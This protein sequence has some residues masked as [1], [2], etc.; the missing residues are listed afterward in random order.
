MSFYFPFPEHTER[1]F[2]S[3][4]CS[5]V[6]TQDCSR[7]WTSA[8]VTW[9]TSGPKNTTAGGVFHVLSLPCS[10]HRGSSISRRQSHAGKWP[11][12]LSLYLKRRI[13][14]RWKHLLC[15]KKKL[16]FC[17][18]LMSFQGLF[19]IVA[20]PS[21]FQLRQFPSKLDIKTILFFIEN[22]HFH[23]LNDSLLLLRTWE[24]VLLHI[25][26]SVCLA[27]LSELLFLTL[28]PINYN[29]LGVRSSS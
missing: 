28:I 12:S 2:L 14:E 22:I 16:Y 7:Q 27:A 13:L 11:G 9:G 10:A 20:I 29:Y 5:Q 19:V 17:I 18:K 21:L 23:I 8:E 26:L 25:Y 1:L 24:F 15:M 6:G 4:P 3:I